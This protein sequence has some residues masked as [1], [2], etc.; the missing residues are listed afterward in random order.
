M[1]CQECK[2][3]IACRITPDFQ[4]CVD[5]NLPHA[6]HLEN[7]TANLVKW[8]CLTCRSNM[9]QK[10]LVFF[11]PLAPC[12]G[13]QKYGPLQSVCDSFFHNIILLKREVHLRSIAGQ[14][15][16]DGSAIT[17]FTARQITLVLC[18][19]RW[20]G[21]MAHQAVQDISGPQST[22]LFT[23]PFIS[24]ASTLLAF[25]L[26]FWSIIITVR[27]I[28]WGKGSVC[29]SIILTTALQALISMAAEN[30]ASSI[31]LSSNCAVCY[32]IQQWVEVPALYCDERQQ[33][34]QNWI[35]L[36]FGFRFL[37]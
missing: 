6:C 37:L 19:L 29:H 30:Q 22:S 1:R 14:P 32:N 9:P 12:W 25:T 31:I 34:L 16:M 20:G 2:T 4:V 21:K 13:S 27:V 5:L 7:S 24:I 23:W 15:M 28:R 36:A 10:K 33:T 18:P 17:N 3:S 35:S 11:F 26:T 8:G